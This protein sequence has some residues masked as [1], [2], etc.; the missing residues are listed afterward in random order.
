MTVNLLPSHR[1]FAGAAVAPTRDFAAFPLKKRELITHI[2]LPAGAVALSSDAL[3]T[4]DV[5][6]VNRTE[7]IDAV[8][9]SGLSGWSIKGPGLRLDT[10]FSI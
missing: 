1:G 8:R 9:G 6:N 4:D 7:Q 3:G 5:F 2:C 10:H